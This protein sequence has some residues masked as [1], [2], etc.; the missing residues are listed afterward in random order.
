MIRQYFSRLLFLFYLHLPKIYR[1]KQLGWLDQP[2]SEIDIVAK[3][4]RK[5]RHNN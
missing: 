4:K 1:D 2:L 5:E 3:T